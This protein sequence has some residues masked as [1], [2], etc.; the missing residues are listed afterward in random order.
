MIVDTSALVAILRKETGFEVYYDVIRREEALAL[1]SVSYLE[2]GIL[3]ATR[4]AA[5]GLRDLDAF[6]QTLQIETIPFS[7]EQS[8]IAVDA[9]SVYGKGRHRAG[10]NFGDCASYALAIERDEPL[11]YKGED[12][13][14]TDVRSALA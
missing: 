5:E 10:L 1:S 2:T 7:A 9:Y 8:R 12:F 14:H 11:L 3:F 4:F 13:S 6:L